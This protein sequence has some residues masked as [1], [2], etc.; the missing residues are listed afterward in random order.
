MTDAMDRVMKP[1]VAVSSCLLGERV[2]YDGEQKRDRWV[3]ETLPTLVEIIGVCPEVGAGMG[4]PRPAI[5][6]VK[7]GPMLRLQI[8]GQGADVTSAFDAYAD[9]EVARL[10]ALGIDGY[11]FKARSPSC[12]AFDTPHFASAESDALPI[13]TASGRWAARIIGE[14]PTIAIADESQMHEMAARTR[15]MASCAAHIRARYR[16]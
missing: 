4:V 2:R 8:V 7:S 3:A 12:G 6:V 15:F 11:L 14:F 16:R 5:R 10:R 9:A 1:R 13:A